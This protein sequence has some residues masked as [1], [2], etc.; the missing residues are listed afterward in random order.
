VTLAPFLMARHE[1]TRGQW[2]RLAGDQLTG[3]EDGSSYSGDRIAIG[4]TH[5]PDSM[6][7]DT[8]DRW[9]TRHGMVLPT[10]AQWEY[11][12]R[13]GTTTVFWPGPT[14]ADLQ[15]CANVHDKTSFERYPQWGEPAPITD[16]F[17]AI[18]SVGHFKPN[19]F[20]LFDVHGNVWEW[21]R[22]WYGDYGSE[23]AGDG[24]RSVSS[25]ASR[26]NRG[27]NFTDAP[28]FALS[29]D[30]DGNSPTNRYHNLGLRAARTFRP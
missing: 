11:G 29:G 26:V 28:D 6:D 14:A 25:P 23:R 13:C 1:L 20:G 17:R 7:W 2:Q 21:C 19:G 16:G 18:A 24:L 22:D 3:W 8:A 4:R 27:G 12:A 9:M 30:R 10:E 5:P 15:G